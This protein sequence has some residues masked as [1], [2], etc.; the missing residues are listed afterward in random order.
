MNLS[1]HEQLIAIYSFFPGKKFDDDTERFCTFFYNLSRTSQYFF[2]RTAFDCD[3]LYPTSRELE[4]AQSTLFITGM[5]SRIALENSAL[6]N[7]ACKY[8]YEKRIKGMLRKGEI[9][10]LEDKIILEFAESFNVRGL[11]NELNSRS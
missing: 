11:F 8:S 6:I 5:I 1:T 3:G 4:E 7:P 2:K 9:W 10:E